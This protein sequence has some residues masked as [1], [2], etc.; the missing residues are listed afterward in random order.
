MIGQPF[1]WGHLGKLI[2]RLW[3][4]GKLAMEVVAKMMVTNMLAKMVVAMVVVAKSRCKVVPFLLDLPSALV[5][6]WM[7]GKWPWWRTSVA[8]ILPHTC[9]KSLWWFGRSKRCDFV[10]TFVFWCQLIPKYLCIRKLTRTK[11]TIYL[12]QKSQTEQYP[13][14][15]LDNF[16]SNIQFYSSHSKVMISRVS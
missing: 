9:G 2:E 10:W 16:F 8:F 7:A 3:K 5:E 14:K 11:I 12:Y 6:A 4:V 13:N 1:F 15:Y